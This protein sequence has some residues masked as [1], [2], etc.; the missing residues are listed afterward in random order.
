M[1][2]FVVNTRK[3]QTGVATVESALIIV[4]F[5]ILIMGIIE[6]ALLIFNVSSLVQATRAG[7]RYLIVSDPVVEIKDDDC[8]TPINASCGAGDCD[9]VL[10]VM[11][12][13]YSSI[14]PENLEATYRCSSTGY[15]YAYYQIYEVELRLVGMQYTFITPSIFGFGGSIDLPELTTTR[16]SEDMESN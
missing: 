2:K 5:L 7:A 9:D 4:V 1:N 10:A 13:F 6:F 15:E 11:K 16:L 8:G 12:K 3:K 14:E